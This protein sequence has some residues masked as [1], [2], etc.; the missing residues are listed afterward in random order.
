MLALTRHPVFSR[1]PFLYGMGSHWTC[2]RRVSYQVVEAQ[3]ASLSLA[4]VSVLLISRCDP[5]LYECFFYSP[6]SDEFIVISIMSEFKLHALALWW[7]DRWNA[8]TLV[9]SSSLDRWNAGGDFTGSLER[10]NDGILS[11]WCDI[12]SSTFSPWTLF[13]VTHS[14][15][16]L[17]FHSSAV[18]FS[19]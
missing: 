11:T 10:W 17:P 8:G 18:L 15:E 9:V 2:T 7:R 12:I 3:R 16:W 14:S 19:Y 13:A 4:Q 5:H 6:F 1:L